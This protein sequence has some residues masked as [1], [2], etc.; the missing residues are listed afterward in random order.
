MKQKGNSF[1]Y[2]ALVALVWGAMAV[3]AAPAV[4][5]NGYGKD[6]NPGHANGHAGS[7][8]VASNNNGNGHG[9]MSATSG[10]LNAAHASENGLA[11][12]N[13][14]HSRVGMLA[15][16]MDAM[17]V[18]DTEYNMVDWEEYDSIQ[19]QIGDIDSQIADLND[20]I[21][22]L[23]PEDPNYDTDKQDLEDQI[24][25]LE[26]QKSDLQDQ[27]EALT[28]AVDAAAA[29]AAGN[30]E[31]AANKDGLIDGDVVHTVNGMLD[32]KTSG[33]TDSGPIH[34]AEQSIADIINPPE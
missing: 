26:S 34:D 12:A 33:F 11:H 9:N 22:A 30:L 2:A 16:Y 17:V 7:N 29:D 18:Y 5:G 21:A 27:A 15:A 1:S 14:L 25:D 32:G 20:Q 3:S 31:G 8:D 23:D 28:A 13:R 4:A 6:N 19:S 10:S 24:A